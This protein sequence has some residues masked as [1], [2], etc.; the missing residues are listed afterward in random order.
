MSVGQRGGL[1]RGGLLALFFSLVA[2]AH[3]CGTVKVEVELVGAET[4]LD[5]VCT[6]AGRRSV[7]CKAGGRERASR[8]GL[9]WRRRQRTLRG[10]PA[11]VEQYGIAFAG[12]YVCLVSKRHGFD[13]THTWS[14]APLRA[15][16]VERLDQRSHVEWETGLCVETHRKDGFSRMECAQGGLVATR[17][18]FWVPSE[19]RVATFEGGAC[20]CAV[21]PDIPNSWSHELNVG[22]VGATCVVG[23]GEYPLDWYQR[24]AGGERSRTVVFQGPVDRWEFADICEGVEGKDRDAA[25]SYL[26]SEL[27]ALDSA[28]APAP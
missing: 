26:E 25:R 2:T 8:E 17:S 18:S 15:Q 7:V 10:G 13:C 27:R 1:A 16:E 20:V 9:W 5:L 11:D 22:Y 19:H 3:G 21:G 4:N 28:R 6:S 12:R 14:G 24:R 23:W